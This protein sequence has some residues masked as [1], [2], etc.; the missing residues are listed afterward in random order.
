MIDELKKELDGMI[1]NG[2]PYED[3]L[4]KSQELDKYIAVEFEK[5]NRYKM[6]KR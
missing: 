3:I 4:K 5:M 1:I 2:E 6:S